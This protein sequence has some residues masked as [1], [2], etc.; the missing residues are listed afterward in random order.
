MR[1][2]PGQETAQGRLAVPGNVGDP[3]ILLE[4]D[5]VEDDGLRLAQV[6]E[7]DGGD[8]LVGGDIT[9]RDIDAVDLP[10]LRIDEGIGAELAD[11]AARLPAVLEDECCQGG[12]K[13]APHRRVAA[14]LNAF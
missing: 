4:L 1:S 7:R 12:R 10:V 13:I 5:E 6:L 3:P 11:L 9:E 14:E 2:L 8:R